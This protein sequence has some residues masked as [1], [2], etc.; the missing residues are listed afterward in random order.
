[1]AL[2]FKLGHYRASFAPACLSLRLNR[3]LDFRVELYT[4]FSRLSIELDRLKKHSVKPSF[5]VPKYYVLIIVPVKP[6]R[7]NQKIRSRHWVVLVTS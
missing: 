2:L 5:L 7:A 1:M 4:G 3:A 6:I